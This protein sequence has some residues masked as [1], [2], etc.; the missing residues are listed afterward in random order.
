MNCV[1][2]F[3]SV[4]GGRFELF[5][6]LVV[7]GRSHLITIEYRPTFLCPLPEKYDSERTMMV[8]VQHTVI[9]EC[10]TCSYEM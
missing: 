8:L 6:D 2:P 10:T 3:G 7:V 9:A 1:K 4:C 5:Y